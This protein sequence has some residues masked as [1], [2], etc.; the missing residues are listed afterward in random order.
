MT[1]HFRVGKTVD[2][3]LRTHPLS[4]SENPDKEPLKAFSKEIHWVLAVRTSMR[5]YENAAKLL[6]QSAE[7]SQAGYLH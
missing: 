5:P 4:H 7:K 1:S 2:S 3:L 6:L